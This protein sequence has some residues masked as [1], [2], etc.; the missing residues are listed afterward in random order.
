MGIFWKTMAVLTVIVGA[1]LSYGI[2]YT[3]GMPT[4]ERVITTLCTYEQNIVCDYVAYLKPNILYGE[5]IGK[6]ETIYMNL[7]NRIDVKFNYRYECSLA[8]NITTEY[9]IASFLENPGE[10][11]WSKPIDELVSVEESEAKNATSAA[12]NAQFSYNITEVKGLIK[13]IEE[14]TGVASSTY[15]ITTKVTINTTDETGVGTISK[16]LEENIALKLNYMGGYMERGGVIKIEAPEKHLSGNITEN[17]TK[18]IES[19]VHLKIAMNVALAAWIVAGFS[20][21]AWRYR[22]DRIEFG[23]LPEPER[24]M[25]RFEVIES[26]DMPDMKAVTLSSMEA[27][28]KLADDYDLRIFHTKTAD[29]GDV[30][31]VADNNIIYRYV[32]EGERTR[33]ESRAEEAPQDPKNEGNKPRSQNLRIHH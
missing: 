2:Y 21:T 27:L 1:I 20:L 4:E 15:Q 18:R 3:M 33:G 8:G 16:P 11:G 22:A 19:V 14:E 31:Y 10:F 9:R 17:Y 29:G 23:T 12:L 7:V 13:R 25:K 32:A 26:K 24:I 5:V 6:G 30:F 28:K